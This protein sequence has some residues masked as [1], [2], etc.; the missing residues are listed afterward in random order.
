MKQRQIRKTVVN[1]RYIKLKIIMN[2]LL[3]KTLILLFIIG[4]TSCGPTQEDLNVQKEKEKQE[5]ETKRKEGLRLDSL[6]FYSTIADSMYN[7][8]KIKDAIT[9]IDSAL[10]YALHEKGELNSRKGN[11]LL[12]RK[13]YDEALMCFTISIETDYDL[14]TIYYQ[15]ALCYEKKREHQLAVNDLNEAIKLG[16][17]DANKLYEKINPERKR[18]AYYVT[19]CC[20]GSTS[21][22]TG[23]GAC[24]HHGGVCNWN[25]PVYE[26]YRK[27][28]IN[29]NK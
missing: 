16:N 5:L 4:L 24:S 26:T 28:K 17:K 25:D 22:A 10:K 1:E 8:K 19:R 29:Q 18:I 14:K 2:N 20:D 7:S 15:R 6:K 21:N 3:F 23:R 13:R 11:W 12:E 27:Y 9:Y